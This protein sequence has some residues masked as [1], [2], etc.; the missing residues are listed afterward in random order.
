MNLNGTEI[1]CANGAVA[2]APLISST[3]LLLHGEIFAHRIP[4]GQE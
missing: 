4:D 3:T 2:G 1:R